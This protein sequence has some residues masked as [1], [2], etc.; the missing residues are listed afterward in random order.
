MERRHRTVITS[1]PHHISSR[2]FY[3]VTRES[4]APSKGCNFPGVLRGILDPFALTAAA[5]NIGISAGLASPA[6]DRPSH[7]LRLVAIRSEDWTRIRGFIMGVTDVCF[8]WRFSRPLDLPFGNIRLSK[9][10]P[11]G[12][13]LRNLSVPDRPSHELRLVARLSEDWLRIRD[14]IMGSTDAY[15]ILRFRRRPPLVLHCLYRASSQAGPKKC[16]KAAPT[17]WLIRNGSSHLFLP[18]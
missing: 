14:F 2:L 18:L 17:R 11:F 4:P 10:L 1:R 8:F 12:F 5:D 13:R 16:L 15:S 9:I 7:E 6:P 3:L